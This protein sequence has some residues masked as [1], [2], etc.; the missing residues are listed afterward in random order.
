MVKNILDN[1]TS[2]EKPEIIEIG[3]LEAFAQ[4][5]CSSGSC[6][7]YCNTGSK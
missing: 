7:C 4:G 5:A 2:Y 3:N 1:L 6:G